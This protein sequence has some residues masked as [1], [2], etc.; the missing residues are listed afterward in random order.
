MDRGHHLLVGMRTGDPQ[1]T[2]M[3]FE[4]ALGARAQAPGHDHPAVLLECLTD[5]VQ[6]LIDGG[7]DEATGIDHDDIGLV[8]GRS[9]LRSLRSAGW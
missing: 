5:G 6:R 1:H 9:K 3:A 7:V 8:I 2:G 4:N